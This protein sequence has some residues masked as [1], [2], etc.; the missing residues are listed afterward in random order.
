VSP[1]AD[2]P[3][4]SIVTPAFN[5]AANLPLLHQRLAAVL[6]DDDPDWEWLVVDDHSAD[7]TFDVVTALAARDPRVRGFRLARNVGSHTAIACGMHHARG[8]CA[9]IMAAD[10]QDP[11]ETLPALLAEWRR[12]SQIVWAVRARRPGETAG[13]RGFARLYYS[14][15]RTVVG[16]KDLPATGADFFLAD[17]AVLDAFGLFRETN[18]SLFALLSWMGFRQTAVAYDKQPRAH[19]RSGWSLGMKLKLVVDSVASFTYLPIRAMSWLG[20]AVAAAGFLYAAVVI[21]NALAGRPPAGWTSLMVVV[22]VLGGL[23]MLMMG[24][25][26]EYLW[27]ALDEARRRPRYLVEATVEPGPARQPASDTAPAADPS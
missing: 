25:L 1:T 23:Q 6:D 9:A 22:L 20:F 19:G 4:L 10:L 12:G 18:V 8:R 17:R 14:L 13:T 3:W 21:A 7:G 16:M 15:M 24:V 27:R 5:E 2:R 11:P 26:G